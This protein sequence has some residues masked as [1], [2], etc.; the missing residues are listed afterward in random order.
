MVYRLA[1][2]MGLKPATIREMDVPDFNSLMLLRAA[3]RLVA[4]MK[5]E[6]KH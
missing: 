4:E 2:E 3:D 1:L 5:L 6:Q